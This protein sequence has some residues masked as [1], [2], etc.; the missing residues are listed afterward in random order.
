MQRQ[1]EQVEQNQ[2]MMLAEVESEQTEELDNKQL[3]ETKSLPRPSFASPF[4]LHLAPTNLHQT[5]STPMTNH[6]I[7]EMIQK[8][9]QQ[10]SATK[11]SKRQSLYHNQQQSH[12]HLDRQ[13]SIIVGTPGFR[14]RYG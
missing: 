10:A 8:S 6:E 5:S 1:D 4:P 11:P 7:Y 3:H 9:Q 13:S 14:E 2:A 12:Q